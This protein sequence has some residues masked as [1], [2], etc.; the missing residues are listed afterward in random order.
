MESIGDDLDSYVR[1]SFALIKPHGSVDWVQLLP[2]SRSA[3]PQGMK[4]VV[5]FAAYADLNGGE[6][7]PRSYLNRHSELWHPA[8]AIPLDKGKTFV[9]PPMHL[10]YLRE[11][12]AWVTHILVIGWRATEQHFLDVLSERLPKNRSLSLCIVDKGDGA[13]AAR[14]NL[15]N[16]L[17]DVIKFEPI[18]IHSDGFSD[19]VRNSAVQEWLSQSSEK[20]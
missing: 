18:M 20:L 9:C 19:F 3:M 5:Q 8:L 6:I 11:R 1:D 12:L 15:E 7:V 17:G 2:P 16:A 10:H 13:V 14:Q 4:S